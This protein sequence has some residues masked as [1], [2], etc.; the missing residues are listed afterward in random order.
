LRP[1]AHRVAPDHPQLDEQIAAV[2][3]DDVDHLVVDLVENEGVPDAFAL[4]QVVGARAG[5]Q[6][7]NLF[8]LPLDQ[9]A[10]M[11]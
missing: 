6:A 8:M 7:S 3:Q 11:Q 10:T 9:V 2:G 5:I 1:A 4:D